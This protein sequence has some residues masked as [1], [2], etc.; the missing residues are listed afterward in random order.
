MILP[1]VKIKTETDRGFVIINETDFKADEHELY[2]EEAKEP[3]GDKK[4]EGDK[5]PAPKKAVIKQPK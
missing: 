1:T 3:E 2:E 4:P 5:E